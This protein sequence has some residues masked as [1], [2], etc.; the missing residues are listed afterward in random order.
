MRIPDYSFLCS[1]THQDFA[2]STHH[3]PIF[4]IC[5]FSLKTQPA[6]MG[7]QLDC[8]IKMDQTFPLL[9]K[10]LAH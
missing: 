2:L 8:L 3:R 6:K 9:A 10:Y 5:F 4:N 7:H 1:A